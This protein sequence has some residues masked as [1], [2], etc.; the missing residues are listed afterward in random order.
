[1]LADVAFNSSRKL[2]ATAQRLTDR[3][4]DIVERG[5]WMLAR[6]EVLKAALTNVGE[7]ASVTTVDDRLES[8]AHRRNKYLHDLFDALGGWKPAPDVRDVLLRGVH[9]E[10]RGDQRSAARALGRLYGGDEDV[11]FRLGDTLRSTLDLSVAAAALEA[12]TFGW[13]ETPGLATLHDAAVASLDPTLRLV[14][15]CGRLISGRADQ[16]DRDRVVRL[17][18]YPDEIGF[19]DMAP[20]R[21]LLSQYWP[22]DPSLVDVALNAVRRGG[23]RRV[24]LEEESAMQY[25]I[26]CSPGNPKVADWVRQELR[27]EHPFA[28]AH[29]DLWDWVAP[30]A[31]EHP[32][33]RTSVTGYVRSEVRRHELYNL[34]KLIVALRGDELR[35]ELVGIARAAKGF[36]TFWAVRPLLDG[37]GR[38]DPVIASFL[39]EIPS[40]EDEQLNSLAEILPQILT[41]FVACRTRLLL[42]ARI[43]NGLALI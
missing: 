23:V 19:W 40:W 29:H 18:S 39:D 35:D 37:W 32:D 4:F 1:L 21:M 2:P 5:D 26:H 16:S 25:L 15:T 3:A 9:S 11:R 12:L 22:N 17:L 7:A 8:W 41:D 27:D 36:E 13:L 30:F 20:A 14:G 33:I 43:V 28:L 42:I 38:C 24:Q 6:R 34:Q 31:M 10:E